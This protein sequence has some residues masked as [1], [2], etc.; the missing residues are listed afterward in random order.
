MGGKYSYGTAAED[1]PKS[2]SAAIRERGALVFDLKEPGQSFRYRL[3]LMLHISACM[4]PAKGLSKHTS[5][6]TASQP[7]RSYRLPDGASVFADIVL[8]TA[9]SQ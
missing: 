3:G 7:R 8:R 1:G 6:D 4:C 9:S 5:E 2:H